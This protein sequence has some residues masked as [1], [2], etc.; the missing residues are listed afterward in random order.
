[1]RNGSKLFLAIVLTASLA[2]C[3]GDRRD[4]YARQRPP[5]DS[6]NPDD[7]GLQSKDLVDASAQLSRDILAHPELR[8]SQ[9]QW[10][11]V[12]DRFQDQ[13]TDRYFAPNY[14]IFLEKLRTE[15]S[16]YGYGRVSLIEN[17]ANLAGLRGREWDGPTENYG[18][19]SGAAG[20]PR[21]QPQFALY[22]K[23]FD[24]PNRATNLYMLQFTLV[25][26]RSG[27]QVWVRDYTVKTAR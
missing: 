18:Q 7:R 9:T 20:A 13:T 5:V 24:M 21:I 4:D 16:K 1:M 17:K 8:N 22:G 6:L 15:L 2:G 12:V 23:A 27:A 10:T 14:N 26:L 25:D 11:V 19:G 3:S